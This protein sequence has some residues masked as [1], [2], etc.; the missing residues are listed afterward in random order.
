MDAVQNSIVNAVTLKLRV[1][2]ARI[3]LVDD[4]P[5]NLLVCRELLE[6]AGLVVIEA[7]DGLTALKAMRQA[8]KPFA[9]ILMD[10]EMPGMGGLEATQHIRS[11]PNGQQVPIVA[12]TANAFGE[13]RNACIAAG[14]NDHIAKPVEPET[15]YAVINKWLCSDSKTPKKSST[16]AQPL[17]AEHIRTVNSTL[18]FDPTRLSVIA[19]GKILAIQ[20]VLTQFITLHEPDLELITSHLSSGNLPAAFQVAH[21]IKGSAGQIGADKLHQLASAVETPLRDAHHPKEDDVHAFCTELSKVLQQVK[22]WLSDDQE[23]VRMGNASINEFLI[24]L[25]HLETLLDSS[26]SGA[27]LVA[28]ALSN[29]LPTILDSSTVA[30]Y[31]SVRSTIRRADFQDAVQQLRM[32]SLQIEATFN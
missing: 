8:D 4:N 6:Q 19:G 26:D 3:L 21:A 11:M 12:I 9:M 7:D 1:A 32:L 25:R 15:L 29:E 5:L 30:G 20:R 16:A 28:E 18:G 31:E 27:L 10:M 23:T 14:M 13:N 2:G 22:R 17:G 24:K